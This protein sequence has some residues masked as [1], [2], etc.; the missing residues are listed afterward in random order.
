MK[1]NAVFLILCLLFAGCAPKPKVKRVYYT[2]D[3]TSRHVVEADIIDDGERK[4]GELYEIEVE[5]EGG[6]ESDFYDDVPTDTIVSAIFF[7]ECKTAID[8]SHIQGIDKAVAFMEQNPEYRLNII[9]Y[10]DKDT[11]NAQN[12]VKFSKGRAVN[13]YNY[14]LRNYNN[15]D[16][17]RITIDWKGDIEQPYAKREYKKNRCVMFHFVNEY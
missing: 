15:I 9:G 1:K 17:H 3:R 16:P 4:I 5:P 11:G 10:A 12:N 14:I 13:T 6:M 2:L 7:G 8:A